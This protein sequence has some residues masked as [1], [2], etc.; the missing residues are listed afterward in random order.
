VHLRVRKQNERP[1][2]R[3]RVRKLRLTALLCVLLGLSLLSFTFGLVRAVASEIPSL[4]PAAHRSDVDT[5]VYA[6]NGRAVLAVL[7]GDES[8]VLVESED[9]A[10]LLKHAIVSVEDQRFFEHNGID[11]RGVAR[12]LW[13]D[14][15]SQAIVEGGS[16]ITQQFVKNAYIRNERT[17][18]RKVREAALAWQL[19]QQW[20]KDR[21]LTA[22]LNTI[23]FGN[24]AYGIQ[25]AAKTYF[26]KNARDLEL[27]EAALLAGLPADPSRYNPATNPRVAKQRRRHVLSLMLEQGRIT[28]AD[29]RRANRAELPPPESIRLPGDGGR[30]RA[31]FFVNYVK[32]QLVDRYRAGG[33]FG[34]GARVT[35][36]IDLKLQEKARAAIE[37]VLRNPEGPAAALVAIEP[38]TGAVKAMYG[39]RNFRES[40]FNLAAQAERQPGSAFKP[41]VLATAMRSG[42]SPVTELESKKVS[43]EAGGR[44]WKVTN[45]DHTYLGRVSL[46]RALVS[47][48]NSVYA[49]LTDLV[50]PAAIVKT[51]HDLGIRSP[52]DAYFSIGLGSV[53]VNPLELARAYA[54]VANDGLRVDGSIL[55]NRPRVVD[56][57][58]WIRN[59]KVEA[60]E[61]LPKRVLDSGQAA[62]LTDVLQDVVRSGTGKRAYISGR[63]VAGKTGTTDNYADA[64]FVGY[65]PELVVA[66]W[67]GYPDRLRP[68]ETEFAGE[69][70]T[71]GTLPAQIWRTFMTNVDEQDENASFDYP[72]YLG[73][74]DTWVVK[75]G[76][77]WQL[78]NGY[79]RGAR[80]LAY[81][82]GEAP[83]R[84]ADCKP[85]EV[86]VPRVVGM[87][88][89]A[90]RA[91][92]AEQ[93]LEAES[94]YV[95]AKAGSAPGVVVSQDPRGG[96]LSAGDTVRLSV[97]KAQH[98]LV[99]NFVGSS[100][101]GIATEVKRLQLRVKTTRGR[102]RSGWCCARTALP[103]S[104][105][106]RGSGSRSWSGTAHEARPADHV[107]PRQV[108]GARDADARGG[109]DL[110]RL[111]GGDQLEGRPIETRAVVLRRDAERLGQPARARAEERGIVEAPPCAHDVE[112][113]RG[114]ERAQE[115]GGS[116]PH[117]AADDVR[118]PV[119]AVGA[120]HVE[121]PRLAEHGGVAR[122]AAAV[123]V[124]RGI[125][126]GIRLD[127]DERAA[128]T[129][130]E[131]PRAEQPAGDLVHVAREERAVE[132]AQKSCSGSLGRAVA[133]STRRARRPRSAKSTRPSSAAAASRSARSRAPSRTA[134]FAPS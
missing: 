24:G 10:P 26:G 99:P 132:R 11:I 57:I 109:D 17:I 44:I 128:D 7:R 67:V 112:P 96:G 86:S 47:S 80:V 85:N 123:R 69:P 126:R 65:T 87:S 25:Q 76:G 92:L 31:P 84:T 38:K 2:K 68:M 70:V 55:G 39:G 6:S 14:I 23:Y 127:L 90:A 46:D 29:Y 1:R 108:C 3:R 74:S 45:Y 51:A 88:E 66:V 111:V 89:G 58:E 107:A 100:L 79:C 81:F 54:T 72:P 95:P 48:D 4:D 60:N 12:A 94:V 120:V 13:A 52:L 105:P 16:T 110:R 129:V 75:R 33:V 83:D 119:D 103:E 93:P 18:A 62:L 133:A 134:E 98:G 115:H 50:G 22:Y 61:P 106:G 40:E 116:R 82:S 43:I 118:A 121:R 53:A 28:Q 117:V 78:D 32:D 130:D 64:W 125:V 122:R 131:Q 34:G 19:E 91:R 114:L 56:E 27:H 59:G 36:T 104:R 102:G 35:T 63:S 42:I 21:I 9:I 30:A 101:E 41:I 77:R 5:V 8:R 37:R 71:G 49:Q 15:R 73:S 113:V 124:A 97:T 20:S